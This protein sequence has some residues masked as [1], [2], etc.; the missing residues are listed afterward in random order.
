VSSKPSVLVVDDSALMRRVISDLLTESNEFTVAGTARNGREAIA[1]VH[2][3]DPDL[4]TLDIEMPELDGLQALGYIMSE[5]P[6]PVVMLSAAETMDGR[7]A[8]L[9]ALELG[10]VDFVR[11]PSGPISLDLALVGERLLGALRAA[12]EANLGGLK[13]MA[14]ERRVVAPGPAERSAQ[15][16][17]RAVAIAASTGGPRAL[18]QVVPALPGSLDAAVLVVQHMPAGFTRSLAQR[19][20]LLS[21]LTVREAESGEVVR[22]GHVYLAPGGRHMRVTRGLEPT[23]LLDD[24]P[25]V[26]GV[27]PAADPLF[28]SVAAA[29]GERA[30]GV[31]LTGMGRDGADGLRA[32]RDAGGRGIVQDRESCIIYGMPKAA[33]Q[34]AGADRIVPLDRVAT[35]IVELLA[36]VGETA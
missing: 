31:V 33:L 35:A 25:P 15:T 24:E 27:R 22:A 19:L 30:V 23:I 28:R 9:R 21:P 34:T 10:A 29:F 14:P 2:E 5:S 18:T 16:P 26:W 6:R 7:D 32:L 3:L 12:R 4:V 8:T 13:T 11:K 1:R 20:D 36:T 17:V